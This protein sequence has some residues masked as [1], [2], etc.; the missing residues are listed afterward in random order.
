VLCGTV[1]CRASA[2]SQKHIQELGLWFIIQSDPRCQQAS[3]SSPSESESKRVRV[4]ANPI[5]RLYIHAN[6]ETSPSLKT[7]T[8][9]HAQP[10]HTSAMRLP[11]RYHHPFPPTR[12]LSLTDCAEALSADRTRLE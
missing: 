2:Y 4:Q 6:V 10:T 1:V 12:L 7:T 11:Q 3:P 8:G 9:C 5:F